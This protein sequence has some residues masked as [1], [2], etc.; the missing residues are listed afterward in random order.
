MTGA[1]AGSEAG[2]AI[3]V[4]YAD[5]EPNGLASMLG[6]LIEQNLARDPRR[7]GLLRPATVALTAT[8]AEVAVTLRVK[9]D[10]VE[11]ANGVDARAHLVVATDSHRLLDLA[12]VPL[13][14][15]LPDPLT[16]RGRGVMGALLR[17]R[18]RVRGLLR[19]PLR[20]TRLNRL[21]SAA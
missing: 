9:R 15:G 14:L 18:L 16:H 6:R 11:V 21:L 2:A 10:R 5:A 19:H 17:R 8:D 20:L 13:Q 12:A 3:A 4:T 1:D 7:R